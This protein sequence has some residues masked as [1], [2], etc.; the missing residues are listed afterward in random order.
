MRIDFLGL[1]AFLSIA[2][3]GSFQRAAAYLNL[4]QT[5]LSHRMR[6]L[7][8]DLGLRLLTRTTR[9]V[10]LTPAGLELLPKARRIMDDLAASLDHLRERGK[11]RQERVAIG[12]LPTVATHYLPRLLRAFSALHP[13]V[14][15]KIYDNSALE[16][17]ELV[18]AGTAEFGLTIVSVGVWDL[19]IRPLL[20]EPFVLLCPSDHA[21]GRAGSASWSELEGMPLIRISPQAGNR[22]LIDD[23]L[24]RRRD[25]LQWRYEVQ[26]VA[27][28]VSMVRAGL[29]LTVVPR[30]AVD[31]AADAG[32][33][34]V[35]LHHPSVSRTL[36]ILTKRGLPL[37]PAAQAMVDLFTRHLR[38]EPWSAPEREVR[39]A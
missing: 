21:F 37:S 31:Q 8:E 36:G 12:C 7:E 34:A 16:I 15:V 33:V 24:G 17:A 6:K 23:A 11:S 18:E 2:E 4:S 38:A 22:L 5:A 10:S 3:L 30:L 32:V 14:T 39:T 35:S 26:H 27:T 25:S 13:E 28:A 20:K 29:G 1:Q 9:Q 19:E